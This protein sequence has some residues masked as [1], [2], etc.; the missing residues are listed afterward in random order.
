MLPVSLID[1]KGKIIGG[2][3]S[4]EYL[5]FSIVFIE[6]FNL[7]KDKYRQKCRA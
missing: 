1:F 3:A 4:L 6:F 7:T 5:A 2:A